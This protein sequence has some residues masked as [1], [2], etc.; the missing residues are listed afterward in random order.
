[1]L[2]VN[3]ERIMELEN[4]DLATVIVVNSTKKH[5]WMLSYLVKN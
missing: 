4:H 2:T 1:M 5:V 3:V